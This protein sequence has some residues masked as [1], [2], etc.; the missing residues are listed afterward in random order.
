MTATRVLV[1]WLAACGASTPPSMP[2]TR[3]PA[4]IAAPCADVMVLVLVGSG[5]IVRAPTDLSVSPQLRAIYD[6]AV[7]EVGTAYTLVARV[8]D[9]P[10]ESVNVLFAGVT[11]LDVETRL[12]ENIRTYLAG[13][14]QGVAA[15][16]RD[17]DATRAACPTTKIALIG[18]SQGAMVVHE[19]LNE[20]A[21]RDADPI[22]GA[23]LL[24]DPERVT[25][26]ALVELG[27]VSTGSHGVCET[28]HHLVSC[29]A[30]AALTDVATPF[31]HLTVSVCDRGD[32]VCDTSELVGELLRHPT[33]ARVKELLHAGMTV[34]HVYADQPETRASGAWLG[35]RIVDALKSIGQR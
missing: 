32:A 5:Q 17:I 21:G 27:T 25:H 23:V 3:A 28:V 12:R 7:A 6:A 35:R 19:V 11:V 9:Y 24:A 22:V 13:E 14:K 10:A 20:R 34:H 31:D 16:R 18:Y 8:V 2:T 33:P 26:A 1:L 30:P 29:T 15:V 4:P